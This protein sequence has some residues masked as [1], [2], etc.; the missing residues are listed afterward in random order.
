[1]AHEN[2]FTVSLIIFHK[3]KSLQGKNFKLYGEIWCVW[4]RKK[5]RTNGKSIKKVLLFCQKCKIFLFC[6]AEKK[7]IHTIRFHIL[8][9]LT[10]SYFS[11]FFFLE[12]W[13]ID[14]IYFS[15]IENSTRI[16]IL[17]RKLK[18]QS[19]LSYLR[20]VCENFHFNTSKQAKILQLLML[21]TK[22]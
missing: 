21:L 22:V 12:S 7:R 15:L 11:M 20:F 1:M 4:N 3:S 14:G 9:L 13:K 8:F 10:A 17:L 18:L 6:F 19:S 16:L 2:F 5:M